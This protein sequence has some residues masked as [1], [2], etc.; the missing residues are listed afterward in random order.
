MNYQTAKD[1]RRWTVIKRQIHHEM[2][3]QKVGY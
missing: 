2:T 3:V 1:K